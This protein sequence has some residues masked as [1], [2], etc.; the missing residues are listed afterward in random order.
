VRTMRLLDDVATCAGLP[1][2]RSVGDVR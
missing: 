1:P 2:R